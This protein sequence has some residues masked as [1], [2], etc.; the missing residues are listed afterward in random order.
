MAIGYARD[1]ARRRILLTATGTVTHAEV[2][3]AI[4][5]QLHEGTWTYGVPL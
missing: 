5:R 2:I 3:A 4:D 1:D